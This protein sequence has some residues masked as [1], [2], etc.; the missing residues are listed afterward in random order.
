MG[1]WKA[2]IGWMD[3]WMD[4]NGELRDEDDWKTFFHEL[5]N[6]IIYIKYIYIYYY[7]ISSNIHIYTIHCI[8]SD[9]VD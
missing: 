7:I 8:D 6:I 4:G 1:S 2:I 9:T 5:I 3:G